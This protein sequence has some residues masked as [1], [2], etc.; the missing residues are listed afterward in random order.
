MRGASPV[1]TV[2]PIYPEAWNQEESDVYAHEQK[3]GDVQKAILAWSL[4]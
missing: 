2:R 1:V 4:R 3:N